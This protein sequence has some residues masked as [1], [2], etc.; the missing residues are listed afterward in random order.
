MAIMKLTNK[1]GMRVSSQYVIHLKHKPS[2]LMGESLNWECPLLCGKT[3][4]AET[5]E[6]TCRYIF[7]NLHYCF[8]NNQISCKSH[9]CQH[10]SIHETK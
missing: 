3:A 4:S 2:C 1:F 8:Q 6:L 7:H 9:K 10:R 5:C